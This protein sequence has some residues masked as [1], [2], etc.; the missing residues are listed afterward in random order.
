MTSQS[1]LPSSASSVMIMSHRIDLAGQLATGKILW[2][3]TTFW[4]KTLTLKWQNL[5][6]L[7][8]WFSLKTRKPPTDR[9]GP[10]LTL[11]WTRPMPVFKRKLSG[12]VLAK[13]HR[14]KFTRILTKINSRTNH[15]FYTIFIS[16]LAVI[17]LLVPK[18]HKKRTNMCIKYISYK[19]V[20]G[21]IRT[22][23]KAFGEKS[24]QK[25]N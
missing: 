3:C 10:G 17:P 24:K 18:L 16:F 11:A 7:P 25:P 23:F 14:Y 20:I 5:P 6:S 22:T 8:P 4:H 15:T 1:L 19:K 12:P 9:S 2:L 21:S 13:S